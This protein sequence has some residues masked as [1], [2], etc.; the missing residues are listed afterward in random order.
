MSET[1][2]VRIGIINKDEEPIHLPGI[3]LKARQAF[4]FNF[5]F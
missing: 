5:I 3:V 4:L 2:L 1:I